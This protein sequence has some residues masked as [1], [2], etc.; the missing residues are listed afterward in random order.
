M[1]GGVSDVQPLPEVGHRVE[2]TE[3]IEE[4]SVA[5]FADLVDDHNSLY[6]DETF[7]ARTPY[8]RRL[9]HG[10]LLVGLAHSALTRLT[11]EGYVLM[12]QELRFPAA[13]AIGERVAVLA[14]VIRVREDKRIVSAET[15]ILREDGEAAF[16]G[17]S[18]LMQLE[19]SD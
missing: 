16:R 9:V 6:T 17:V 14:E 15:R 11:G 3:T 13:V 18:G 8:G 1:C 5:H 12:G 7:A 4:S 19:L 10:A 2:R